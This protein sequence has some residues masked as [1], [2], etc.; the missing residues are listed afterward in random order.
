MRPY[1]SAKQLEQRRL[2]AIQLLKS[3]MGPTEVAKK[4]NAHRRTVQRWARKFESGGTRAMQPKPHPGPSPK[5]TIAQKKKLS[6]M[7]LKGPKVCGFSTDLWTGPRVATLIHRL[8]GV[9]YHV[10]HIGRFLHSLGW[11]P[12]KPQRKAYERNEEE[13][14]GWVKR[15]WPRIKKTP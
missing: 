7:L 4:V 13:I 12:Q 2:R 3:G 6:R 1:G 8:F 5:L 10:N 15:D 9:R 14:A 11:T